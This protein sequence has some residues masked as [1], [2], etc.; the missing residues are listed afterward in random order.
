MTEP[1]EKPTEHKWSRS[2]IRYAE[3][4]FA[5]AIKKYFGEVWRI[6]SDGEYRGC[7]WDCTSPLTLDMGIW[8]LCQGAIHKGAY[9][10][11]GR[12]ETHKVGT[13]LRFIIFFNPK[14]D[15]GIIQ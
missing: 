8:N 10:A 9:R 6:K 7:S 3:H 13:V 14:E 11:A 12:I 15:K 4:L 1:H 5:N 2:E